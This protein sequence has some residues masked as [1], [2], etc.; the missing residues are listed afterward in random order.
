MWFRVG[1]VALPLM[2]TQSVGAPVSSTCSIVLGLCLTYVRSVRL[3]SCLTRAQISSWL[4]KN[5]SLSWHD[6]SLPQRSAMSVSRRT[7]G[8]LASFVK[9]GRLWCV[10]TVACCSDPG[11]QGM[12]Q[13]R[14]GCTALR[15]R[16]GVVPPGWHHGGLG[17][18]QY[19]CSG[20]GLTWRGEMYGPVRRHRQRTQPVR[21]PSRVRG[22]AVGEEVRLQPDER[23]GG[24]LGYTTEFMRPAC[25]GNPADGAERDGEHFE[26][27]LAFV[28]D[29]APVGLDGQAQD[30]PTNRCTG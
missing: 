10:H 7:Q 22:A 14:L 12:G 8:F 13:Q 5:T 20:R 30:P 24:H 15:C 26:D 23:S 3:F 16:G 19:G 4:S 27:E 11:V 2:R 25:C 1:C 21:R 18:G 17:E 29:R 6:A 28:V 9:R